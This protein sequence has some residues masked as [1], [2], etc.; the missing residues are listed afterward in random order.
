MLAKNIG[1][2]ESN[3][4]LA[5]GIFMFAISITI[6]VLLIAYKVDRIWRVILFLPLLAAALGLFQAKAKT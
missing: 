4:R 3:K 5:L 6:F 1:T 2:R